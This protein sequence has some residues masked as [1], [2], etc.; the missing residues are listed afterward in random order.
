MTTTLLTTIAR[1]TTRVITCLSAILC[2][3]FLANAQSASPSDTTKP[4]TERKST[5]T[6]TF[7]QSG[8]TI[9]FN[10]SP[11]W[12]STLST[13]WGY[14]PLNSA[15][16]NAVMEKNGYAPIGDWIYSIGLGRNYTWNNFQLAAYFYGGITLNSPP[17]NSNMRSSLFSFGV[18]EYFGYIVAENET[19]RLF[20]Q[21]G[22]HLNWRSFNASERSNAIDASA[23]QLGSIKPQ[24]LN[25]LTL[26][27]IDVGLSV[28]IGGDVRIPLPR[29]F[30]MEGVETVYR[31]DLIIGLQ[32]GYAFDPFPQ[33]RSMWQTNNGTRVNNL[34]SVSMQGFVARVTFTTDI[35]ALLK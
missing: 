18:D 6:P 16:F 8:D 31:E 33:V 14:T 3:T 17:N 30:K 22:L 11:V 4:A 19:F 13:F 20:P 25:S 2:C 34:P 10:A 29:L 9:I 7:R 23:L 5:R 28:G 24:T 32:L 21:V 35:H 15:A 12:G 26:T 27:G 1:A